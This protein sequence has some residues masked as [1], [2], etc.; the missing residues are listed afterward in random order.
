MCK[1]YKRRRLRLTPVDTQR[2]SVPCSARY[3]S[4]GQSQAAWPAAGA[5]SKEAENVSAQDVLPVSCEEREIVEIVALGAYSPFVLTYG[6]AV[7]QGSKKT[8][9]KPLRYL[10]C[11]AR[12]A[13]VER[14]GESHFRRGA[15]AR[16]DYSEREPDCAIGA[17]RI[18]ER[19]GLTEGEKQ[20]SVRNCS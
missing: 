10:L 16:V 2:S 11:N 6:V 13:R 1:I 9:A 15:G 3:V 12:P 8:K 7:G 19:L 5:H 20:I 14:D 18:L 4:R 17:S